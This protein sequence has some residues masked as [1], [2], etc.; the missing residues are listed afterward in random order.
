MVISDDVAVFLGSL[1]LI[2][3]LLDA[4]HVESH[5]PPELVGE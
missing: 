5:L 2:V 4:L 3:C 1:A